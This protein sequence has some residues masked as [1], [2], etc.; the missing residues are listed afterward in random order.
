MKHIEDQLSLFVQLR[1]AVVGKQPIAFL[2][3]AEDLVLSSGELALLV[4]DFPHHGLRRG[5]YGSGFCNRLLRA[6]F[7]SLFRPPP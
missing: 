1:Q 4:R 3:H 2:P 5:P 6:C 7:I